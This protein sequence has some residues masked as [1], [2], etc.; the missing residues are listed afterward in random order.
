[1]NPVDLAKQRSICQQ[2]QIE[3]QNCRSEFETL[4][5][6]VSKLVEIET[7]ARLSILLQKALNVDQTIIIICSNI[8]MN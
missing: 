3:Y 7:I 6:T 4:S 1:M 5:D 2:L 8:A